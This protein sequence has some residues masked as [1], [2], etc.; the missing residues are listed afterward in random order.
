MLIPANSKDMPSHRF[1][2]Q[3]LVLGYILDTVEPSGCWGSADFEDWAPTISALTLELFLSCGVSPESQWSFQDV[4]KLSYHTLKDSI[5]YLDSQIR[6]DGSFGEDLWDAIRLGQI[7]LRFD[8]EPNFSN[9]EKL[10]RYVDNQLAE[11]TYRNRDSTWD[12]PGVLA[13]LIDLCEQRNQ[14]DLAVQLFE[15]LQSLQSSSG[16]FRGS[17]G[18]DGNDLTSPVWHTAQVLITYLNR[19]ISEKDIRVTKILD[20]LKRHQ[21]PQ[22]S[23]SGFSRYEVYFTSYAII[24]LSKLSSPPADVLEK[25]VEW[26][27]AQIA[28]SGKVADAGGTLMVAMALCSYYGYSFGATMPIIEYHNTKKLSALCSELKETLE[29]TTLSLSQKEKELTLLKERYRN[30]DIIFSNKQI[31]ILMLLIAII[32]LFF[33]VPWSSAR[34]YIVEIISEATGPGSVTR[35]TK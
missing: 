12:G 18:P 2:R 35:V 19:G 17:V 24:G 33:A 6:N 32:G 22:G 11:R 15:E 20:W 1:T 28:P 30:A 21:N 8:L 23:W 4:D 5:H 25:A 10:W 16:E 29:Q 9:S 14:T 3:A 27:Q 13:G 34:E 26:L 31:F 7:I